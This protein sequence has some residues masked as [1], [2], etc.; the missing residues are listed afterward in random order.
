[1]ANFVVELCHHNDGQKDSGDQSGG[2]EAKPSHNGFM[3]FGII[4][5]I[6]VVALVLLFTCYR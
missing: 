3:T 1:M 5:I 2:D 4:F 6:I